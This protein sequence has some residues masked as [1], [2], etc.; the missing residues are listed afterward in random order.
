MPPLDQIVHGMPPQ[1]AG[2]LACQETVGAITVA[3]LA[4]VDAGLGTCLHIP[5]S[6]AGAPALHQALGAPDHFLPVWLQLVGYPAESAD[7]GGTRPR[8]EYG[9]LF[10]AGRWGDPMPRDAAVVE[11]L[12]AE[13]VLQPEAPL[14]GRAEELRHLGRMFGYPEEG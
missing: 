13:G 11:Q 7:A 10:S 9:A 8:D 12:R 1:M 6:P 14:P 4:A 2:V 5:T 3:T